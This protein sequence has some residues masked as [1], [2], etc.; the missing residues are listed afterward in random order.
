MMMQRTSSY[1]SGSASA[2]FAVAFTSCTF[3]EDFASLLI[4]GA[5]L[6]ASIFLASSIT[7]AG[8]GVLALLVRCLHM[9]VHP[10]VPTPLS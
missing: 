3:S 6:A 2:T 5:V 7:I 8:L 4:L 9:I 1:Q 10:K